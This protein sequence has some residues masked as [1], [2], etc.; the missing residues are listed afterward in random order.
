MQSFSIGR[1]QGI[2]VRVHSTFGLVVLWIIY[3]FGLRAES[4]FGTLVY[5]FVWIL[6]IFGCVVLHELGHSLMAKEFGIRVN[7]ITLFPF[8]GAAFIEQMPMRP[9]SEFMITIAG[10]AVNVAIAVTLLPLL[11]LFGVIKGFDSF[12]DYL[13]YL[14]SIAPSGL[15][16]YLF[17]A[18][19]MIV[20]FNLLPAFPMD[21]GRLLRAGLSTFLSRERA[22]SIAV[23]LGYSAAAVLA[24]IGILTGEY[25]LPL[26]GIFIVV[27]AYAEGKA[28]RLESSMRRLRV[29]QFALWDSG[30]L[31]VRA[32]LASALR[33]GPRDMVVT[34]GGKVMGMLWRQDVLKALGG[35]GGTQSVADVMEPDDFSVDIDDSVYDVQQ[36]MQATSRWA[37]PVVDGESYRGI[38]TVERFVHVYS[39]LNTQTPS[40][41]R[42]ASLREQLSSAF[43]GVR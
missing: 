24:I 10:P 9:R 21:G 11:L 39:Y 30:G 5:G 14:E 18:N 42:V 26:L 2:D 6:L 33:G 35:G 31:S 22:T 27:A 28:V 4:T 1:I 3:H 17:F 23:G 25:G 20:L 29:G 34:D 43:R 8:G 38:F 19:I 36:Q 40:K 7:N 13:N 12:G 15:L 41:R 32:P 16:I 37:V